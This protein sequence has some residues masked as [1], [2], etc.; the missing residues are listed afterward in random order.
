MQCCLYIRRL[1]GPTHQH[2]PW[3]HFTFWAEEVSYQT[4]SWKKCPLQ[5][6]GWIGKEVKAQLVNLKFLTCINCMLNTSSLSLHH[7]LGLINSG[8]FICRMKTNNDDRGSLKCLIFKQYIYYKKMLSALKLGFKICL[9]TSCCCC[10]KE[11]CCT[12]GKSESVQ[13]P[14]NGNRV[15]IWL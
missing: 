1:N 7:A 8:I 3:E 12:S 15:M 14:K 9:E 4:G 2:T 5:G 10:W 11:W 13:L 6:F